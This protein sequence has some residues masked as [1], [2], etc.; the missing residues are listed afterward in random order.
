MVIQQ[1]SKVIHTL[2]M[3]SL[4]SGCFCLYNKNMPQPP[5][6]MQPFSRIDYKDISIDFLKQKNKLGYTFQ[7]EGRNYGNKVEVNKKSEKAVVE[8]TATLIINAIST[9]EELCKK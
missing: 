8:A 9:Y 1:A 4:Y 7:Y 5:S 3:H 6:Y 2:Q